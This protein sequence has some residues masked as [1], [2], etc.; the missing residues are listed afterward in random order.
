MCTRPDGSSRDTG[1]EL[2]RGPGDLCVCGSGAGGLKM[3]VERGAVFLREFG[4]GEGRS[5]CWGEASGR[6][7]EGA[8]GRRGD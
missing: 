5:S 1:C 2:T 3:G 7:E 6:R 8:P 4:G